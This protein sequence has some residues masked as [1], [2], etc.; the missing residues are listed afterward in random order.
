MLSFDEFFLRV[1]FVVDVGIVWCIK[2][3]IMA[4][5]VSSMLALTRIWLYCARSDSPRC[6]RIVWLAQ[7][8]TIMHNH[9]PS[10][11][12]RSRS[13]AFDGILVGA[14]LDFDKDLTIF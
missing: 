6:G 7:L 2:E 14:E 10:C 8:C 12:I 1:R 4:C 13:I 5:R 11:T 3:C 9:A